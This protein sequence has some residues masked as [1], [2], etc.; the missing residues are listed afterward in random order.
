MADKT[1]ARILLE[2]VGENDVTHGE[3]AKNGSNQDAPRADSNEV[4]DEDP[5]KTKSAGKDDKGVMDI[6][7]AGAATDDYDDLADFDWGKG[8]GEAPEKGGNPKTESF[9]KPRR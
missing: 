7:G 8:K 6:Y 5:N 4:T 3:G 2:T 9:R 1:L